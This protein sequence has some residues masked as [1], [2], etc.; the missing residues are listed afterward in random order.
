MPAWPAAEIFMRAP[1]T[2]VPYG[3][4]PRTH[5]AEQIDQIAAS[6]KRFGFT[7]PILA[8]ENAQVIAGHARLA[9]AI[10]LSLAKVPVMIARGWTPAQKRAYVIADNKLSMNSAWDDALLRLELGELRLEGFDLALTGFGEGELAGIFADRTAGLTDPDDVPEV[11][12]EPVSRR[13]DVWIMAAHR[14][15]CGDATSKADVAL[16]LGDARPH[17][18]VTDPPYGV[19]YDPNWRNERGINAGGAVGRVTNDDRA[20]WRK[21]WLLFPGDVAYVWHAGLQARPACESLEAAGF[22]LRAQIIWVKAGLI[23]GRGDY[24]FQ[25][26]PCWYVVRDGKTGHWGGRRDQATVWEIA[27]RKSETGHSTQKPTECMR[28]PIENNSAAGDAVYDPFV[29]SG[30]TIIAAEMTGR[31]CHAMEITP[32]YVDVAVGRWQ[33]FTGKKAKLEATGQSFA[34]IAA[35]RRRMARADVQPALAPAAAEP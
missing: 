10:R 28:R 7:I 20:D 33:K 17:L 11:P 6:I 29:G 8:D 14:L 16:S 32:A 35:R 23:I 34:Q 21:A 5:S 24:H 12:D 9:A 19:D 13:G 4:N 30:T 1:G 2:L 27:H 31:A 25:H 22:R 26:E 3:R 15:V 18:M